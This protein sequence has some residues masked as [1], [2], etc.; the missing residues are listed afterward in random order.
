MPSGALPCLQPVLAV[1]AELHALV[2]QGEAA[3]E[4]GQLDAA[5]GDDAAD[6]RFQDAGED[7][8]GRSPDGGATVLFEQMLT[9]A[10][11][12]AGSDAEFGDGTSSV[13]TPTGRCP[14]EGGALWPLRREGGRSVPSQA[15]PRR[16]HHA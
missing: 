2:G 8:D 16:R 9:S 3:T 12:K 14:L 4:A 1:A 15:R 10:A 6:A 13:H 5:L 7:E 11:A